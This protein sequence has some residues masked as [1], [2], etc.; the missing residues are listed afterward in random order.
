MLHVN[1]KMVDRLNELEQ[2]LI[3]RRQHAQREHWLGEI[4]G[5]DLT[6]TFLRAKR[7]EAERLSR[8]PVIQL[9]T[10]RSRGDSG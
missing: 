1:P 6:L 4:E 7:E 10:P 9:G 3:T 2:D 5:I 8:R